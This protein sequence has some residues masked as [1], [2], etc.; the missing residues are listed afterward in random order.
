MTSYFISTTQPGSWRIEAKEFVATLRR[1]WPDVKILSEGTS[2]HYSVLFEVDRG[3][4]YAFAHLP[5]AGD[6]L[7]VEK[8]STRDLCAMATWFRS[9]VPSD[10]S[11]LMFDEGYA[12]RVLVPPGMTQEELEAAFFAEGR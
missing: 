6:C 11:L 4:F 5:A 9:I 2:K 12:H 1:R 10:V 3:D 7:V 8:A